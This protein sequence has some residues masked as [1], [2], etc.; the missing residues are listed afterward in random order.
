MMQYRYSVAISMRQQTGS[1]QSHH[2]FKRDFTHGCT[3]KFTIHIYILLLIVTDLVW[4]RFDTN[5]VTSSW[6]PGFLA[7]NIPVV[8]LCSQLPGEDAARVA[9]ALQK[10]F[11]ITI[12][13]STL[14]HTHVYTSG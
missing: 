10:G 3:S 14:T 4:N 5:N 13:T 11:S 1:F 9:V 6:Y 7:T 2:S 8:F 12:S